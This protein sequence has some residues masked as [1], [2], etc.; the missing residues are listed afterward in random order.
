MHRQYLRYYTYL[1]SIYIYIYVWKIKNIMSH[2]G[3][4]GLKFV[5]KKCHVLLEKGNKVENFKVDMSVG[6]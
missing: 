2:Q 3:E 4:G 6:H 5:K 1:M